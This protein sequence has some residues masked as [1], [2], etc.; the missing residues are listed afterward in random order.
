MP[1]FP[2]DIIFGNEAR[3]KLLEGVNI[4]AEAVATT[5]GPKGRNV[6]FNNKHFGIEIFHDGVTV[7]RRTNLKDPFQDMGAEALKQAAIKTNDTAGD[8]TTTATIL[9]QALISEAMQR[10]ASGANPMTLKKEIEDS[11]D[12]ILEALKKLSKPIVGENEIEQ[13]A[14]ISSADPVLG[15]LVAEAMK[16]VGNDGLIYTEK[17]KG[18][19]T[20]VEYQQGMQID[21]G[22]LSPY[23]VN[24]E[25]TVEAVIEKPYI[26]I[27]DRKINYQADLIPLMEKLL[28]I[29]NNIVIFAGEIPP[30]EEA[31]AFLVTNK[32]NKKINVV[33]VQAPAYG[34]RR[35]DELEDIA[36]LTG[37]VAIIEDSGRDLKSVEVSEL[38]Q[39]DKI[40][41]DRDY[42]KILGGKGSKTAINGR[43][44]DL[45][46]QMKI[47]NTDFDRDIKEQRLAK[48]IGGVAVINV[49]GATEVEVMEKKER[50]IDAVNATK[51]AVEEGVVAGGEITLLELSRKAE[52]VMERAL[53]APFKRL[54]ENAGMDYGL[55][56]EQMSGSRYPVGINVMTGK[57]VDLLKEGVIDPAKVTRCA[58]ENACSVA[59]ILITTN[60]LETEIDEKA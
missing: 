8:G 53:Q 18:L 40:I 1:K 47:A 13:I 44:K 3:K 10:I 38:G 11:R 4:I 51:A 59:S 27:T 39:A 56:R 5:L 22:Y 32:L 6:A 12:D 46:A 9:A 30:T 55:V 48:L 57:V 16:T 35:I 28:P 26:L 36:T 31:M 50:I 49:G 14:T 52:G 2:Q 41:V 23:F 15:K 33:A 20:T 25:D 21:R 45:K 17:G 29:S 24:K 43:V 7:A 42:T 19:E 34:G 37:G 58:I 54:I 60:V